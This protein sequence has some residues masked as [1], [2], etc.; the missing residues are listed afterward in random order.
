[1][2]FP[3]ARLEGIALR[4]K[5]QTCNGNPTLMSWTTGDVVLPTMPP[6]SN[7]PKHWPLRGDGMAPTSGSIIGCSG[8]TGEGIRGSLKTLSTGQMVRPSLVLLDDPQTPESSRSVTQNITR[9]QLV[10]AD[11]LGMAGPGKAISAIMPCTVISP[12]DFIDRILDRTN[13]PLWRGERSGMLISMPDDMNAWDKYFEVYRRCAG[14][15]PPDFTESNN[16]YLAHQAEL[17]KGASA[18]WQ[19]RKLPGEISAIQHAMH[20]Y[21]RDRRAFWSE[22]QNK[23]LAL[24]LDPRITE[25]DGTEIANRLNRLP[26]LAVAPEI[27]RL[28]AFIDCGKKVLSYVVVGWDDHFGG[29]VCDYGSYPEQNRTYYAADDARPSLADVF[30]GHDESASVY[31]GLQALTA[32]LLT[33]EYPRDG[34]GSLK[35]ERCGVDAGW[36][37]DAVYQFCRQSPYSALLQPTK[38]YGIGAGAAP[39]ATWAPK[40]GERRGEHWLIRPTTE[41]GRGR[42]ALFDSNFWKSFVAQRLQTPLGGLGALTLWGTDPKLHQLFADHLTSEYRIQTEGRGRRVDE[43]KIKPERRDNH[44]FDGLVG[45]AVVASTL[46]LKWDSGAAIGDPMRPQPAKPK[47]ISLRAK[48]ES[49]HG[50]IDSQF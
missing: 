35:V 47:K 16:Y 2:A 50:P 6:P 21:C 22:Y 4:A 27:T 31:A 18:S 29:V 46:G 34:G 28:T 1:M 38:G 32:Q 25:L 33:R 44:L 13:Y 23:P 26:R 43:W 30:P 10:S 45:C 36:L 24:R 12:G 5:G 15:E 42:L 8:L 39:M 19:D 20:L 17:E 41:S 9:E 11:V 7:W 3:V 49:L 14:K 48:Y 37:T 40:P